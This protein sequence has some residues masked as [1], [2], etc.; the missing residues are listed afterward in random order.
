VNIAFCGALGKR[1]RAVGIA[2]VFRP[3][4]FLISGISS[5]VR[6]K[7]RVALQFLVEE[8]IAFSACQ[9]ETRAASIRRA[10]GGSRLNFLRTTMSNGVVVVPLVHVES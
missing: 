1:S 6:D 5:S 10:Q 3:L 2:K 4:Q 7:C 8:L 9:T